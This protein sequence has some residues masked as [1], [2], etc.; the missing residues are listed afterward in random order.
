L[1]VGSVAAIL[2]GVAALAGASRHEARPRATVRPVS[3]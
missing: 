1:V 3:G 2:A